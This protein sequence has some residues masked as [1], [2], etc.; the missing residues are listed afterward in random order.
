MRWMIAGNTRAIG[1]IGTGI[2][3]TATAIKTGI[4]ETVIE[5]E[6]GTET[7][8]QAATVI[9]I[10]EAAVI[11]IVGQAAVAH[12]TEATEAVAG[13]DHKVVCS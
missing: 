11:M 3:G 6:T 1:E 10:A 7:G 13:I 8:A 9:V 5:T 12:P 2:A 4:V